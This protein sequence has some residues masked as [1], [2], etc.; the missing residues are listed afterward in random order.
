METNYVDLSTKEPIN[1]AWYEFALDMRLIEVY[2]QQGLSF[3]FKVKESFP[4][5]GPKLNTAQVLDRLEAIQPGWKT[6][7]ENIAATP[8]ISYSR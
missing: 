3:V 5:N 6:W 2:R 7:A 8:A 4:V 1:Y